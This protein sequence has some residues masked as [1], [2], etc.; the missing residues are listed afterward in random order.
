MGK[1]IGPADL[2]AEVG[3]P[4]RVLHYEENEGP[5]GVEVFEF[6]LTELG[7]MIVSANGRAS[8]KGEVTSVQFRTT[9]KVNKEFCSTELD[10][11]S[12]ISKIT[13]NNAPSC[14]KLLGIG[15][16]SVEVAQ[17][18]TNGD[19]KRISDQDLR[20]SVAVLAVDWN[21]KP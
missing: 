5:E 4:A 21:S 18:A 11:V 20:A 9:I 14:V 3:R 6:A 15:N 7:L 2:G 1:I 13:L 16:Y 19:G 12:L 17:T 10:H 8:Y